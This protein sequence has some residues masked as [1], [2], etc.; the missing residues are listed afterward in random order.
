MLI[1]KPADMLG[2]QAGTVMEVDFHKIIPTHFCCTSD[3]S[4]ENLELIAIKNM[5]FL[6]TTI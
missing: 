4:C 5:F 2:G 3:M 6:F 1:D